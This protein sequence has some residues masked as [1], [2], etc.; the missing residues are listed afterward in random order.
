V[1]NH[2]QHAAVGRPGYASMVKTKVTTEAKA[3]S[4]PTTAF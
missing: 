4:A 3:I 1:I 2:R